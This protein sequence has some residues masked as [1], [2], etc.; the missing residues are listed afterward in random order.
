MVLVSIIIPTY[1]RAHVI[2]ETLDSILAQTH[3]NWECIIVDDHSSDH[4][5]KTV[6]EYIKKDSRFQFHSRPDNRLKGANACRNYGFELSKGAFVNWFDSDDLMHQD[7]LKTL[8][9]IAAEEKS[10]VIV[11][12]NVNKI[13][14]LSGEVKNT[15]TFESDTFYIDFILGKKAVITDDVLIDRQIIGGLTFDENLH[16]AQEFDFFYR[17]FEQPLSYTFLDCDAVYHRVSEDSISNSPKKGSHS[18]VKSLIYLCKKLK[19]R[20]PDNPLILERVERQ[21]RKTYK[22]LVLQNN[23]KMILKNFDF[24]KNA[25]HKHSIIF[26]VCLLYNGLTHR[27]FDKMK[28]K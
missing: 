28:I 15:A 9:R 1:N 18:Q 22:T 11:T 10:Q 23:I 13:E 7:R 8:I 17:L 20:Y 27:G 19:N 21:A 6:E 4:T 25:F 26:T 24:F 16:K 5:G 12:T 14:K 2:R 3:E